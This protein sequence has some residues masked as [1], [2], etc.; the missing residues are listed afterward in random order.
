VSYPTGLANLKGS[1]GLNL[2]KE[3]GKGKKKKRRYQGGHHQDVYDQQSDFIGKS[4][5]WQVKLY[6]LLLPRIKSEIF[7]EH[8]IR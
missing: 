3:R 6:P 4:T 1:V 5:N 8:V 7:Q 2:V